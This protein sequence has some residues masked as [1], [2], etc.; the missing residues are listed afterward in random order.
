MRWHY[1]WVVVHDFL[2]RLVG[3]K[4]IDDIL[5]EEAYEIPGGEQKIISPRLLFFEWKEKP[6]M[7]LEFSV[8]A[9]RFGHS[10]AEAELPHQRRRRSRPPRAR[11]ESRC[12]AQPRHDKLRHPLPA[13]A[14]ADLRGF[15]PLPE[16]T[17][18]WTG[19]TSCR[20]E[21]P[22]W[23]NEDSLPQPSYR[24]DA[25]LGHPL[26]MLPDGV[27]AAQP[28][29]TGADPE[30]ARS[31]PARNLLRASTLDLPS[32]QEVARAMGIQPLPEKLLDGLGLS[33]AGPAGILNGQW[34]LWFYVLKEAEVKTEG[35][36]LGP[37]GGRIVAEVLIG[38]LCGDPLSFF[39]AQPGVEADSPQ[40]H[41]R[42]VHVDRPDQ[43]RAVSRKPSCSVRARASGSRSPPSRC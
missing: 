20:I 26:G 40:P 17:R 35:A 24:I 2:R 6:F 7:P 10:M 31:L 41:P 39:G 8:A 22:T 14:L 43:L 15:R 29:F 9:Y 30:D 3:K 4:V 21:H 38:L 37:V 18:S 1:Q 32:G 16:S 42:H 5:R 33:T 11:S 23:P 27:A 19:S 36:H 34:P 28:L 12:S 13:N 25:E